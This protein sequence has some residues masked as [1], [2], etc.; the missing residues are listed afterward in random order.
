MCAPMYGG[1]PGTVRKKVHTIDKAIS[2][3]VNT[4]LDNPY[5]R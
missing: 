4:P 3:Q 2:R 5:K 1:M